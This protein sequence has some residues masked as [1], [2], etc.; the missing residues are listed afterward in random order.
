MKRERVVAFPFARRRALILRLARQMVARA[1]AEAE[2]YLQQQLRRQIA[3]LHHRQVSD[4]LVEQEIGTL[5]SAVR[6]E[7]WRLVLTPSL[8]PPGAA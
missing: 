3:A 8:T 6:A 2:K 5:E 4:R 7:L 1:P